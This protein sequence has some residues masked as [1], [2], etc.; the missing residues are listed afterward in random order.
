MIFSRG[1]LRKSH[2]YIYGDQ[3]IEVVIEYKYLRPVFKFGVAKKN[4]YQKCS[5]A[6]FSLLKKRRKM[7][8]PVEVHVAIKLLS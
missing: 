7:S 8:S 6:M 3:N 4:L 2:Y 5:K 1:K